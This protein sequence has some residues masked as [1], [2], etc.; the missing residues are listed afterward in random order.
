[1][2]RRFLPSLRGKAHPAQAQD[3]IKT[4]LADYYNSLAASGVWSTNRSRP[5]PIARA[6]EEGYERIIWVFKSVEAL[7]GNAA[8]LP[9][10]L[11]N[12]DNVIKSHPLY[13]VLNGQANPM[14]TGRQFRKRLAAQVLLSKAGAFVELTR[15]RGGD[16]IRMDLLP[17]GRTR[18]IPGSDGFT[19][20][21][22]YEVLRADGTRRDI[23]PQNVRWFREPHPTDPYSG[24]TPL[25]AAGMSVELDY[26][27]RLYNV[28]FLKNDARPGGVLAIDGEMDPVEMDRVENRFGKGPTEAGRLSVINGAVS[29]VDLATRPRDMQHE[30]TAKISKTEILT[31]FGVPESILGFSADRTYANAEQENLNFWTVTMPPFLDVLATGFDEDSTDAL[32]TG[33][34]TSSITVLHKPD[35]DRREEARKEF[36]LGLI[37][38]AE[39]RER[40]GY[41]VIDMP[42]VRCL[43]VPAAKTKTPTNDA[44]AKKIEAAKPVPPALPPPG[45]P[46]AAHPNQPPPGGMRPRSPSGAPGGESPP[47]APADTRRAALPTRAPAAQKA[48]PAPQ[49]RATTPTSARRVMRLVRPRATKAAIETAESAPDPVPRDRLESGIA[50]ALVGVVERLG[51]RTIARLE[52]PKAR[53]GTRHWTPDPAFPTDTRI[54]TKALD[55]SRAVDENRWEGEAEDVIRPLV[56]AAADAAATGLLTDLGLGAATVSA[57]LTAAL[58]GASA[59]VVRL[60]GGWVRNQA[61]RL[62]TLINASDQQGL[63]MDDIAMVVRDRLTAMRPW[64]RAAA[65]QAATATISAGRE[66]GAQAAASVDPNAD[67]V[68]TWRARPDEKVRQTHRAASGQTQALGSPFVVGDALLRY[69]GDPYGPP[70]EVAQCRCALNYRSRVS[71]QY[72]PRP[73]GEPVLSAAAR[74]RR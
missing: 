47:V 69:P 1:M 12:G 21:D 42:D 27:A 18:P 4:I 33:W 34:D 62:A 45:A 72:A 17:P 51:E 39:Y 7:A 32:E 54:G 15:S 8:R 38:I 63:P 22:H 11:K 57:P 68:R 26:F 48:L 40:A 13:D 3:E 2:P 24:V 66:A 6:V 49:V 28:A 52:S 59:D 60:V 19:L 61:E 67:I 5:W 70:G 46:P 43:Y 25:E 35:A 53:K 55:G 20:I 14:E 71:G 65:S 31:A 74:A 36:D 30:Q 50:T 10:Q 56:T 16:I 58:Y 73:A 9:F 23:D 29:Y 41:D 64:A 37:S 44:D